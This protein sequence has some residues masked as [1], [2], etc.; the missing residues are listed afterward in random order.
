M[1]G[2]LIVADHSGTGTTQSVVNVVYGTSGTP[3]TANTTTIGTIYIQ[4]T[5]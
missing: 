5:A 3:P 2:N 1:T 4:Y